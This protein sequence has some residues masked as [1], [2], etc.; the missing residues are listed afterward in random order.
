MNLF[1][2]IIPSSAPLDIIEWAEKYVRMVGSVRGEQFDRNKFPWTNDIIRWQF[3]DVTRITTFI[4]PI[5]GGGSGAGEVALCGWAKWGMG[6]IQYNWEKDDKAAN[7]WDERIL[8]ILQACTDLDWAGTDYDITVGKAKF[9]RG[10]V[11]TQGVFSSSHLDSDSVPYQ[12]NEEIHQWKSGHLAKARGRQTAVW[13]PKALDISNAGMVGDQLHEAFLQGTQQYWEVKCPGCC[14]F[15]VMRTRWEDNR[16]ELGGLRYDASDCKRNDG[17]FDY[18]KLEKTIFMQMP[19]GYKVR[20]DYQERRALSLSG[21]YGE[22][23]NTGANVSHRS[24]TLEAVSVDYISWLTLIKEKHSALR[25]LRS[26]DA[27]PFR[28]YLQER[29][30]Q[31]YS[32]DLH[33]FQGEIVISDG[34]FK[35]RE[36]MKER[37]AGR[38]WKADWQQGWKALG[39]LEHFWL[40]I[41][42]VDVDCNDELIFE[43]RIDSEN[44]L[45]AVLNDY[46]AIEHGAGVVDCSFNTRHLL[47][48]CFRNNLNAVMSNDSKSGGFLHQEDKV[49][50]FYDEGS[51][52]C[53]KL[54]MSPLY[55]PIETDKGTMP[56]VREP[57]VIN[58][59]KGGMIANHFFV[60]EHKQRITDAFKEEKKT[61]LPVDYIDCVIPQDVSEDF[62]LQYESWIRVGK[63]VK[64]RDDE[65]FSGQERFQKIRKDDH[66]LICCAGI[67]MLKDWSG[68]LGDRLTKLGL[69]KDTKI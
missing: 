56:D 67:D 53:G 50:R 28:R 30:C 38:L 33:P 64:K 31:F 29:E 19:C 14:Q 9:L 60:R 22:P 61:A 65:V 68:L 58:V 45:I 36:G 49:R 59:S 55:E 3:D 44:E 26:G 39:Q 69:Q 27:E 16:P 18:N 25:S 24:A 34:V 13:N 2:D 37:R 66:L 32:D 48:F 43:G 62:K 52:I 20:D 54:N 40:V 17:T 10:F 7:K 42:D 47:E 8:P 15:H 63:D 51:A 21:R 1:H 6:Q 4:K 41:K 11:R 23:R 46:D 5:Q 12:L 35:K 57:I